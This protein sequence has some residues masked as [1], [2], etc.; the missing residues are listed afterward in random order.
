MF[1]YTKIEI[2]MKMCHGYIETVTCFRQ[3]EFSAIWLDRHENPPLS[4][5]KVCFEWM[6]LLCYP[7][8]DSLML[9]LVPRILSTF[10]VV[11]MLWTVLRMSTL[12]TSW[13][14]FAEW[15][16]FR[17]WHRS[18]VLDTTNSLSDYWKKVIH[19]R[20]WWLPSTRS[21]LLLASTTDLFVR[22][23]HVLHLRF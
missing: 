5:G 12:Q 21:W 14:T 6:I 9:V 8:A 23:S 2:P 18:L 7:H 1:N 13:H 22:P 16:M 15:F 3:S 20:A 10:T 19:E 11:W 4:M 17:N